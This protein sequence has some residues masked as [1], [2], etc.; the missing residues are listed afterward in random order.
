M[1]MKHAETSKGLLW[2][3]K[4]F[5]DGQDFTLA[6]KASVAPEFRLFLAEHVAV[7]ILRF[8]IPRR[9]ANVVL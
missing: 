2:S 9:R 8:L 5:V 1:I 7:A 4:E 3:C 6:V